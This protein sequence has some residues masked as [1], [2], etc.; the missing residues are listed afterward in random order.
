MNI[1][2]ETNQEGADWVQFNNNPVKSGVYDV[3]FNDGIASYKKED[4]SGVSIGLPGT[5]YKALQAENQDELDK[6]YTTFIVHT[7]KDGDKNTYG[8][9]QFTYIIQFAGIATDFNT[10]FAAYDEPFDIPV[11]ELVQWL[12]IKLPAKRVRYT[13]EQR[14]NKFN[15]KIQAEIIHVESVSN[16]ADVSV[17]DDLA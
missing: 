16:G 12:Q 17:D 2:T 10:K 15:D 8:E 3:M 14:K 4:S 9:G 7:K 1:S 13:L 5:I 6:F 11:D